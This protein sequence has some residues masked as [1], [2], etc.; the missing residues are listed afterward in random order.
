MFEYFWRKSLHYC[1][2]LLM[3]HTPSLSYFE[4]LVL[5]CDL[6]RSITSDRD[7]FSL[8]S[9]SIDGKTIFSPSMTL[10][11]LSPL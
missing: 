9:S 5:F 11:L 6:Y 7:Y 1:S 4:K 2:S 8:M 10:S 3:N